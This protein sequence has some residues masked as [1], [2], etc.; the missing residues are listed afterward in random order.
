MVTLDVYSI[1][2]LTRRAE[3]LEKERVFVDASFERSILASVLLM[4]G[5]MVEARK[6][7]CLAGS[8]L[9]RTCEHIKKEGRYPENLL[10]SGYLQMAGA[11]FDIAH[12]ISIRL[13]RQG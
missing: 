1:E 7:F 2:E 11:N 13:L 9:V 10:I 4:R 8:D 6:Q 12:K 3:T 5:R